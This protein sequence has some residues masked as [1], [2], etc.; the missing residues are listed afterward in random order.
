[1]IAIEEELDASETG[2]VWLELEAP[3]DGFGGEGIVGGGVWCGNVANFSGNFIRGNAIAAG[4][5]VKVFK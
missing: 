2:L 5:A 1:L 4:P 3:F